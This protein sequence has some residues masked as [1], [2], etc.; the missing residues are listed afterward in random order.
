M[1][2]GRTI[3]VCTAFRAFWELLRYDTLMAVRGFRVV[4]RKLGETVDRPPFEGEEQIVCNAVESGA[5]F[6]WK[7]VRCLQRAVVT[8]RILRAHGIPA[9]L[10]IGCRPAPFFSHAWVEVRGRV[11]SGPA[12]FPQKLHVLERV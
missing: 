7:R 3:A 2:R 12:G 11:V 6:Y 4:H 10:V 1:L 5:S 8:A 9:E